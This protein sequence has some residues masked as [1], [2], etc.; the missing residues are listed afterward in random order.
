MV[1]TIAFVAGA[2]GACGREIVKHLV[3]QP[4]ISKVYAAA[5]NPPVAAK[6]AAG[7]DL[8]ADAADKISWLLVTDADWERQPLP[9]AVLDALKASS[10]VITA[11]G[12]SRANQE[13][14]DTQEASTYAQGF[15]HWLKKVDLGHNLRLATAAAEAGAEV[16]VRISNWN[17]NSAAEGTEELPWGHYAH[18]Q[19]RADEE[20]AKL[21]AGAFKRGVHLL[22]VARLDRGEAMRVGRGWEEESYVKKGPGLGVA[23][24]GK[25]AVRAASESAEA[26]LRVVQFNV[27]GPVQTKTEL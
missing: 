24:V 25:E 23:I 3:Q 8:D 11:M 5:R 7:L 2:T 20:I 22:R 17:A 19:G 27:Q 16:F 12:T 6:Y 1:S 4:Q 15:E 21:A 14:K 10:I 9:T 13:V 18:Y 26:G